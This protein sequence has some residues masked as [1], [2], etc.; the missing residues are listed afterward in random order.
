MPAGK[1]TVT[2]VVPHYE[3]LADLDRCLAALERQSY[4]SQQTEIV[5]ADNNSPCGFAAVERIVAGRAKVVEV[6][7]PGAAA[8]RNGAVDQATGEILAFTDSDC[9]PCPGWIENGVAALDAFDLVGGQMRVSAADED[10]VSPTEAFEKVFAFDNR[11][12]VRD[13]HFSVTAN[14]FCRRE[15]F[16]LV[17]P[18]HPDV[19]E[20]RDWCLRARAAGLRI[21]YASGA[22][23]VHPGR[24]NWDELKKKL[25][26]LNA[27]TQAWYAKSK[28]GRT[29]WL[30]RSMLLPVSA[31]VHTPKVL[32]SSRLSNLRERTGALHTLYRSRWWRFANAIDI[33][34]APRVAESGKPLVRSVRKDYGF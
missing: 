34:L 8:A 17:G 22:L 21:G 28:W 25:V 19:S 29:R 20:D 10:H 2:V 24:R 33:S 30:L 23:V 11:R 1:Q 26:R 3:A 18:F 16:E 7:E 27:E 15:H 12:Y 32:F 5:V 13:K 4:P 6:T 31:V 9:I 14:L